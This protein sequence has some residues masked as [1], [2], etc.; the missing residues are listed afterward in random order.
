MRSQIRTLIENI[1]PVDALEAEHQSQVLG[2]IDSG[3]GLFRVEKPAT[4]SPHLVSYF[5]VFDAQANQILLVDHKKAQLWL[6]S[7]GHV[8]P[9]EH[10]K[11]T[12]EREAL[13][14]LNLKANFLFEKPIFVTVTETVGLTAGHI[15][16]SLWY[17]LKHNSADPLN[18]DED[19]F[20]QIKWFDLDKIPFEKAEPHLKRFIKK[21]T[22]AKIS[23]S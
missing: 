10:P 14:E 21:L 8:E 11:I 13:E 9:D 23:A 7:G 1:I 17:V 3:A 6:P 18:F 20:N 16:V 5:V 2:W 4:P 19:E 22:Y 12:A 15:D